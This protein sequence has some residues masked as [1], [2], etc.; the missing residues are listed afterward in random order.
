MPWDSI[1]TFLLFGLAAGLMIGCAGIGGVILVPLLSYLGGVD[2]RVAIAAAMFAY[3]IS[4]AV[5]TLVFAQQKSI[6]WDM[7][8]WMWV[9][10]M[11][12]AFAGAL[13]VQHLS[14]WLLEAVIG[15]LT[16]ASGAHA[17]LG[18]ENS[19]SDPPQDGQSSPT[20]PRRISATVGA[21]TGFLSAV[22]GTGG[23]LVLIPILLWFQLPVLSAVGLAQ[24]IQLPI[25]ALATAGNLYA[26]SLNW[27]LG[28]IV[29]F[30]ILFGTWAGARLAH[31]LPR[32]T[33]RTI[34]SALLVAVG[35]AIVF[36]LIATVVT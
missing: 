3:L 1:V 19:E 20:L 22:S 33:L 11:P 21:A 4:G 35:G 7:T 34:V 23:P 25:A 8:G 16:T 24:A 14:G 13:A 31:V 5:G 18:R 36:K 10:A 12:A 29:G 2:I 6:R 15:L 26:E 27:L 9:G 30:G 32:K 28:F 17:L